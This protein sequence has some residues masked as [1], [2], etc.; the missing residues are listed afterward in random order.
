MPCT[1][2]S[3][4]PSSAFSIRYFPSLYIKG[5]TPG[6]AFASISLSHSSLPNS[7][8]ESQVFGSRKGCL[9]QISFPCIL[10]AVRYSKPTPPSHAPPS[11]QTRASA[12]GTVCVYLFL[13]VFLNC[14]RKF[15]FDSSASLTSLIAHTKAT[16]LPHNLFMAVCH[17]RQQCSPPTH[18]LLGVPP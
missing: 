15:F 10:P 17:E 14:H 7:P 18:Q 16:Q 13:A 1:R 2:P 8:H 11:Y 3:F 9:V 5:R 6:L 12:E 4:R